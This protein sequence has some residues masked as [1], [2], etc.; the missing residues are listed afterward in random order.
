[1]LGKGYTLPDEFKVGQTRRVNEIIA[2]YIADPALSENEAK[3]G[4]LARISAENLSVDLKDTMVAIEKAYGQAEKTRVKDAGDTQQ[5][6]EAMDGFTNFGDMYQFFADN[7][8]GLETINSM[9]DKIE[10]ANPDWKYPTTMP[11]VL[12]NELGVPLA[13]NSV[14]EYNDAKETG[15]QYFNY[16]DAPGRPKDTFDLTKP[17]TGVDVQWVSAEDSQTGEII[18][19]LR[20]TPTGLEKRRSEEAKAVSKEA[21]AFNE[22]KRLIN[23]IIADLTNATSGKDLDAI[24]T[25]EKLK[26]PTGVIRESDISTIQSALG[27]WSDTLEKYYQSIVTGKTQY[28]NNWERDQLVEVALTVFEQYK[29]T[30][31]NFMLVRKSM[32]ESITAPKAW[33]GGVLKFETVFPKKAGDAIYSKLLEYQWQGPRERLRD[34]TSGNILIVE[35]PTEGMNTTGSAPSLLDALNASGT[36]TVILKPRRQ[37]PSRLSP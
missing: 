27:G 25:L 17:Q 15:Y 18:N 28:L 7:E 13:I 33:K 4:V 34:P 6:L 31:E 29:N 21:V 19:E 22:T 5:V 3:E 9:T 32:Y 12:Y 14:E 11:G 2:E 30:F 26:D 20:Y 36:P 24:K 1:M 37:V 23:T 35:P 8:I 16:E 10:T